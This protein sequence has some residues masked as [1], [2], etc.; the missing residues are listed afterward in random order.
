[1]IEAHNGKIW[2]ENNKT[3]GT[4]FFIVLPIMKTTSNALQEKDS[5]FMSTKG[6]ETILIIDDEEVVLQA[7]EIGFNGSC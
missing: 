2:V 7:L 4:S 5:K 6:P 3:K 1:M